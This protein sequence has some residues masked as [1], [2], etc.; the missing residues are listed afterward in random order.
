[1]GMTKMTIIL[2]KEDQRFIEKTM[3][4]G[5]YASESEVVAEAIAE[6][7]IRKQVRDA[8]R[9]ELCAQIA[10]GLDQ[11]DRGNGV[12]WNVARIRTKGRALLASRRA[13]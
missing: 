3:E 4:K 1:M 12:K 8:R 6:F 10:T 7:K 11:L 13:A 2:R 9:E 5:S